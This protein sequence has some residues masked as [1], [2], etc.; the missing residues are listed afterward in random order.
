MT[1]ILTPEKSTPSQISGTCMKLQARNLHTK[2]LKFWPLINFERKCRKTYFQH[3]QPMNKI[4]HNKKKIS[5]LYDQS[6]CHDLKKK[7]GRDPFRN[8]ANILTKH[9]LVSDRNFVKVPNDL[10]YAKYD[11]SAMT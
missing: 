8:L 2:Y 11:H 10:W 9:H 5:K 3:L 4:V 6:M 1:M 7:L